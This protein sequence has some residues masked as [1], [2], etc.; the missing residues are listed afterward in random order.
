MLIADSNAAIVKLGVPAIVHLGALQPDKTFS[1]PKI[2][3]Q[4]AHGAHDGTTTCCFQKTPK[5]R[6]TV[7]NHKQKSIQW[8]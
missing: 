3:V 7:K 6:E 5:I 2:A 4:Y 1:W 8:E